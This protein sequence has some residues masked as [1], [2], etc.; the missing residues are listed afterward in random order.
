M[1]HKAESANP[2]VFEFLPVLL[3]DRLQS[4]RSPVKQINIAAKHRACS[5]GASISKEVPSV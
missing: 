5:A 2:A 1:T 4:R 3:R